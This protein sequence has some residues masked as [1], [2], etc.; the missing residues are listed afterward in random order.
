MIKPITFFL[1]L[2]SFFALQLVHAQA[3]SS[4]YLLVFSDDFEDSLHSKN[5]WKDNC[6]KHGEGKCEES[7]F[8]MPENVTVSDGLLKLTARQEEQTCNG[9]TKAYTSGQL[10]TATQYGYGYFEARVKLPEG[11]GFWPAFWLQATNQNAFNNYEEIDIFENCGC[12]CDEIKFGTFYE[13]DNNGIASDNCIHDQ[14]D[15]PVEDICNN[16]HTIG[17]A[18]RADSI[19]YYL[20]GM[21]KFRTA[22]IHNHSPKHLILNLAIE[23]CY[24]GCGPI[25]YCGG[26]RWRISRHPG[27]DCQ[28]MCNT[29]FP[30][31]YEIDWVRVYQKPADILHFWGLPE[32]LIVGTKYK[33]GVPKHLDATYLPPE[34]SS[35][36]QV[37]A[38]RWDYRKPGL[39]KGYEIKPLTP[40]EHSLTITVDLA[41][42]HRETRT[43]KVWAVEPD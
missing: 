20:D 39:R 32:Q 6:T 9:Q 42:G 31:T 38:M 7:M 33:V 15:Y 13:T 16:F 10:M 43:L 34:A 11:R 27:G 8:Y 2:T 14:L 18:W 21:P 23:G 24:G 4:D 35:D 26:L 12:N 40:G 17:V 25:E 1:L 30:S 36:M 5:W 29:V 22:N 28:V 3:P 41:S 19:I 37:R